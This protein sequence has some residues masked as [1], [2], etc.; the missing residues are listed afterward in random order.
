[1]TREVYRYPLSPKTQQSK[2]SSVSI[3]PTVR[4]TYDRSFNQPPPNRCFSY[5]TLSN[6]NMMLNR[7]FLNEKKMSKEQLA[8]LLKVSVRSLERFLYADNIPP[9]LLARITIP[10][11]RLYCNTK[12]Q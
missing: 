7:F 5:L 11:A 2:T 8:D 10:L 1:M 12:W 6:V 9:T 3:G 4:K